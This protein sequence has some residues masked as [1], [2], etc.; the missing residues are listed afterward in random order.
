MNKSKLVQLIRHLSPSK[1]EKF[2]KYLKSPYFVSSY[3]E[4]QQRTI[5]FSKYLY[6]EIGESSDI[7]VSLQKMTVWKVLFGNKAY[8]DTR[9]RQEMTYLTKELEKFL[10]IEYLQEDKEIFDLALL[11]YYGV[12]QHL[13]PFSKAL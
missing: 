10:G 6:E 5:L 12:H 4:A 11:E 2:I 9:M 1:R 3:E 7:K 8:N 13:H